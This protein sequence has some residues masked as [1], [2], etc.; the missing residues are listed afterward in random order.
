VNRL[1]DY[2]ALPEALG[3]LAAKLGRSRWGRSLTSTISPISGMLATP[4]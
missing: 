4:A 3:R 2:G 1:V